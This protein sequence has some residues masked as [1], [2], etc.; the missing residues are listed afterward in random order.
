MPPDKV[1]NFGQKTAFGRVAQ[2]I[3]L[4]KVF[5]FLASDDAT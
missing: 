5:V 4:A 1:C 2:P 3:E